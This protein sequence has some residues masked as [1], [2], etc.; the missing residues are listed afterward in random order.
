MSDASSR[1]EPIPMDKHALFS[2]IEAM[3]DK[4]DRGDAVT[5][6]LSEAETARCVERL[7]RVRAPA[8]EP[9]PDPV[10]IDG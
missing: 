4:V 5:S 7:Q 6:A 2:E 9:A 1:F 10:I 3:D 8:V